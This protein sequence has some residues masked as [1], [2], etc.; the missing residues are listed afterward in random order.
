MPYSI[1]KRKKKSEKEQIKKKRENF[2]N[3]SIKYRKFAKVKKQV[4]VQTEEKD[5]VLE[6]EISESSEE[7][8]DKI[9]RQKSAQIQLG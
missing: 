4:K 9:V 3:D 1:I 6:K 8:E 5:E 2:L 7:T